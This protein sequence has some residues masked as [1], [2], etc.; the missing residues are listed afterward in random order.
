[1]NIQASPSENHGIAALT[2]TDLAVY[3]V[4]IST[5]GVAEIRMAEAN[6]LRHIISTTIDPEGVEFAKKYIAE[7]Q[8]EDQIEVKLEDVAEPLS[9]PDDSFDYIYAR[10][11]LHYL[12]KAMLPT[13]LAGLH[14]ILKPNGSLYVVVRSTECPDAK[15]PQA[16]FDPVTGLTT[17]TVT[18]DKT[19]KVYTYSRYFHTEE[20]IR[21]YVSQAGFTV[22]Y[23]KAYDEQL[24][25]D[26]MRTKLSPHTDNV[27]ELFAT[28]P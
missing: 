23:T 7:K 27:I 20:S 14:R 3:S 28:K 24:Y 21:N 6:P 13:A 4:G 22:S 8:L 5:G 2:D 10:L 9:Y 11:V 16:H 18:D 15:R 12:P 19:G 26:F 1:M 25:A 17:C